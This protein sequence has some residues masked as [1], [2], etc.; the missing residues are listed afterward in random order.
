MD[1]H[2]LGKL[3][4]GVRATE[5]TMSQACRNAKFGFVDPS[6]SNQIFDL[7]G[8]LLIAHT[9]F[10]LGLRLMTILPFFVE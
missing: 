6:K 7:D 4:K 3:G 10:D 2:Q 8:E 5:M 9:P 1:D